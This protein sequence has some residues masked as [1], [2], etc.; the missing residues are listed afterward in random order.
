M[1]IAVEYKHCHSTRSYE[2]RVI[3]LSDDGDVYQKLRSSS[4]IAYNRLYIFIHTYIYSL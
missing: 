1:K 3:D 4:L 2:E